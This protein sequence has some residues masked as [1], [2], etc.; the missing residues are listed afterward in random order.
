MNS[1]LH[2]HRFTIRGER[3]NAHQLLGDLLDER[4]EADLVVVAVV[5][6]V[7]HQLSNA[8]GVGF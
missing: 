2:P 1:N 8:L 7:L 6:H 4:G 5:V 3:L